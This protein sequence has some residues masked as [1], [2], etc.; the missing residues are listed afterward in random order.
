[1]R[2]EAR[3]GRIEAAREADRNGRSSGSHSRKDDD[4]ERRGGTRE[5]DAGRRDARFV[6]RRLELVLVVSRSLMLVLVGG[7]VVLMRVPNVERVGERVR[8]ERDERRDDQRQKRHGRRDRSHEKLITE[9]GPLRN[10][11]GMM[12]ILF[13]PAPRLRAPFSVVTVDGTVL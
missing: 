13:A 11:G 8:P 6:L 7:V 2:R 5:L 3:R 4:R 10:G 1:M 9:K 12:A